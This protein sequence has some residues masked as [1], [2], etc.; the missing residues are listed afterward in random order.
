MSTPNDLLPPNATAAEVAL[1]MAATSPISQVNLS[2]VDGIYNPQTCPL[3]ILP[4]LAWALCVNPWDS[5]W[6]ESQQRAAVAASIQ[7]HRIRGTIGAMVT[8]LAAIGF[9]ITVEENVDGPFTFSIALDATV[10][11]IAD[12]TPFDAAYAIALTVK[13][14]RSQLIS[15]DALLKSAGNLLNVGAAAISGEINVLYPVIATALS[16]TC[17]FFMAATETTYD[18]AAVYPA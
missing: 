4:W 5:T 16:S 11:G 7:V 18:T 1:E 12:S 15:V 3:A 2:A 17:A 10:F 9:G 8:A 6:T 14:A 13:N